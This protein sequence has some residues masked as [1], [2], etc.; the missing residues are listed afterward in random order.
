MQAAL[1]LVE[2][3]RVGQRTRTSFIN[4]HVINVAATNHSYS[5]VLAG[6]DR[7]YA[8]GSGMALAARLNRSPLA[9]NVNG[10]D[11]FP[12][13]C[14]A[15]R[16]AGVKIFLLGGK[17]GVAEAAS[18][19]LESM[20][21]GG[22]VA[23][24]HHGYISKHEDNQNAIDEINA[25]GASMLLVGMGVPLQDVWIAQNFGSLQT[26]VV[27]GVGGLFDFFSGNVSRAPAFL[28]SFGC[29]WV[30]R[31]MQEPGRLWSRYLLG[32]ALFIMRALLFAAR[33]RIDI[34]H[35]GIAEKERAWRRAQ[36]ERRL[37]ARVAPVSKRLLDIVGALVALTLFAPV[38][39]ATAIAIKLETPGPVLF[40]QMRIGRNGVPFTLLK[41]RSMCDGADSLHAKMQGNP[42]SRRDLRFKCRSDPRV[43]RTGRFIR[44]YSIDELPQFWNVLTGDMSLVGPR[45][46]L[47]S[48]VRKYVPS[49]RDRL[50]VK[51][52][53]TCFWQVEGRANIDFVGQ[54]ALDRNYI[55]K[56][57][58]GLDLWLIFRTPYAVLFGA[59]A[60]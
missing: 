5:R 42:A 49:D 4:A 57:S 46:A 22:V 28:R 9:D 60:Y 14:A 31:L 19:T 51:P 38:M 21:Y 40:R 56:Q 39:L 10:T 58:I 50:L 6:M 30:W 8:D 1:D 15:A 24:T 45:P 2:L 47:P 48:E 32:N 16:K 35:Y 41:F 29:E 27:I 53:I 7:L 36:L 44:K 33:E 59:G 13:L 3:A 52:G 43:T 55:R 54:V 26:P 23:G 18:E 17:P 25:S 20:G 12:L 37:Y 34:K 11:L